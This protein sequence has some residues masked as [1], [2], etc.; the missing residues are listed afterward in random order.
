VT[1]DTYG[2][3]TAATGVNIAINGT[4]V[5]GADLTVNS[6]L[7]GTVTNA[8]LR[9]GAI[10]HAVSG[11][12]GST[13]GGALGV[14]RVVVNTW[15]HITAGTS[16]PLQ[17]TAPIIVGSNAG[18]FTWGHSTSGVTTGTYGAATVMHSIHVDTYGHVTALS[19]F[20]LAGT[21][22]T[23]ADLSLT[24]PLIFASGTGTNV[25]LR[26]A[27]VAHATSGIVSGTYGGSGV[28]PQIVVNTWGH[29]TAINTFDASASST[30]SRN[31]QNGNYAL[32]AVDVGGFVYREGTATGLATWTVPSTLGTGALVTLINEGTGNVIVA[33]VGD[34]ILAGTGA[35]GNRTLPRYGMASIISVTASRWLISGA[36]VS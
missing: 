27:S 12:V 24:S 28:T 19:T 20:P 36:G 21:A 22:M 14:P 32:A 2:H 10:S 6:P 25:L 17:A 9:A 11:V 29:V 1:V 3:V 35:T 18:T 33:P 16:F 5:T 26:A 34:L 31:I 15:G 8:L 4:A 13:Y 23:G 30:I 7:Q